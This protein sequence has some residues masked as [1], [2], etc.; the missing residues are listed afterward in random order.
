MQGS[1]QRSL[2]WYFTMNL[3]QGRSPQPP[4][5]TTRPSR[6]T[7]RRRFS[8]A[9]ARCWSTLWVRAE[10]VC[11]L[12]PALWQRGEVL[13]RR[14]LVPGALALLLDVGANVGIVRVAFEPVGVEAKRAILV[15]ERLEALLGT[16]ELYPAR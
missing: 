13:A 10:Q 2:R 15:P 16:V 6:V 3:R 12:L 14:Q 9:V 5:Q 8:T 7:C 4:P 1:A 11:D